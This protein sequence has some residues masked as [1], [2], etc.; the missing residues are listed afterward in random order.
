MDNPKIQD[1]V[2]LHINY[3]LPFGP[4]HLSTPIADLQANKFVV[5]VCFIHYVIASSYVIVTSSTM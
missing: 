1:K 2:V 5:D 4:E 3:L